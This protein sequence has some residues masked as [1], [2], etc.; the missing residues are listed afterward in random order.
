MPR[1]MVV[2]MGSRK[3]KVATGAEHRRASANLHASLCA[4]EASG[5]TIGIDES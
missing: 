2:T 3:S 5:M 1:M 4:S